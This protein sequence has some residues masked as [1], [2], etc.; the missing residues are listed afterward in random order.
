MC[1]SVSVSV[2]TCLY[3]QWRNRNW[4]HNVFILL[5]FIHFLLSDIILFFSTLILCLLLPQPLTCSDMVCASA[6]VRTMSEDIK[7]ALSY[8]HV[9]AFECHQVSLE[10]IC[11]SFL[12]HLLRL[13]PSLYSPPFILP[14]PLSVPSL[15]SMPRSTHPFLPLTPPSPLFFPSR[16]SPSSLCLTL[17]CR[18][19]R[20]L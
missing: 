13:L 12:H 6:S 9:A 15:I 7:K 3:W 1:V 17:H 19:M 20:R 2:C 8:S 10:V 18:W 14:R 16:I 4:N 5:T 11:N